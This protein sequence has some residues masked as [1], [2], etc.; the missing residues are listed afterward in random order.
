MTLDDLLTLMHRPADREDFLRLGERYNDNRV[1]RERVGDD[2]ATDADALDASDAEQGEL[3]DQ[4]MEQIQWHLRAARHPLP[5]PSELER[6]L[7]E[8]FRQ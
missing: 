8:Y 7:A 4:M 6:M 2:G 5:E 1:R 3:L